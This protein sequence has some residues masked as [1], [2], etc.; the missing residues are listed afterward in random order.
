MINEKLDIQ[1]LLLEDKC[2]LMQ[3]AFL[4][5]YK[6]WIDILDCSKSWTRQKL[7]MPLSEVLQLVN[8]KTHFTLFYRNWQNRLVTPYYEFGF[9]TYEDP[10]HF[11]W[12]YVEKGKELND[13]FDK[14]NIKSIA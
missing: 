2:K 8:D 12:I 10:T 3:D 14:Y 13:L 11:L 9:N 7:E 1:H 6:W 5:C 4:I